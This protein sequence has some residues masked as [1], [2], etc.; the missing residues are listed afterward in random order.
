MRPVLSRGC[1]G[2][3]ASTAMPRSTAPRSVHGAALSV[4]ALLAN[5][6]L[7]RCWLAGSE[8][9]TRVRAVTLRATCAAGVGLHCATRWRD[10]TRRRSRG[11]CAM[12][13]GGRVARGEIAGRCGARARRALRPNAAVRPHV[14]REMG[15]G[16]RRGAAKCGAAARGAASAGAQRG[17][18]AARAARTAAAGAAFFGAARRASGSVRAL[19]SAVAAIHAEYFI[20]AIP[21]VAP[22]L[23]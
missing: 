9:S 21:P 13:R 10:L 23:G 19:A 11:A 18:G 12:R 8:R 14:R 15:S 2:D 7:G 4:E 22:D 1:A 6:A 20:I 17:A 3:V 5:L 16:A